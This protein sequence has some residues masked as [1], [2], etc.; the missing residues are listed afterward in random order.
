MKAVIV[1]ID[2]TISDVEHRRHHLLAKPKNWKAFNTAMHFDIPRSDVVELVKI[3]P[4]D[5]NRIVLCKGREEVYRTGTEDWLASTM[6]LTT[7]S[8]CGR[9]K[10]IAKMIS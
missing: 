1:D 8:I 2:G 10:I 5:D 3:L 6:C 9:R 7:R 4:G